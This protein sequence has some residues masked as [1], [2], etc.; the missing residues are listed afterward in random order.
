MKKLGKSTKKGFTLVELIVVLVIL[1]VL[2][3]MLVP[4]LTG[5]IKRARQ[6]K[7]YQMAATVLTAAQSAATYQYSQGNPSTG[8]LTITGATDA[9]NNTKVMDLIG[10]ASGLV[11]DISFTSDTNGIITGGSVKINKYTYTWNPGTATWTAS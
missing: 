2:A 11:T 8:T 5:Y 10:D 7:D 6:E 4:A 9:G 1:A 3:A